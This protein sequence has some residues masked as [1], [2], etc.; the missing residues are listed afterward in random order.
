MTPSTTLLVDAGPPRIVAG[1]KP[2]G[3]RPADETRRERMLK[4]AK[5]LGIR[6]VGVDTFL[7]MMG[8]DRSSFDTNRLRPAGR[9][10]QP[11]G[12]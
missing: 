2:A 1:E 12:S 11:A 10:P 8:L 9:T 7:D 5:R 4:E 6:V 3:W